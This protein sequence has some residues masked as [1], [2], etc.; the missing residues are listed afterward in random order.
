[1]QKNKLTHLCLSTGDLMPTVGFGCWKVPVDILPSQIYAAIK[2]GYR[3]ID[4]A[5]A[6][7]NEAEV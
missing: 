3:H 2:T 5:W 7:G 6:Y 4:E 1:M